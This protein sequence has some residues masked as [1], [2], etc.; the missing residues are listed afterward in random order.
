MIW[1]TK[2]QRQFLGLGLKT[3]LAMVCRLDHKTN[4]RMKTAQDTRRDLAACFPWK[5]DGLWFPSFASKLVM[6]RRRVLHVASSWRSRGS[7]AEDGPSDSVGGG[8]VEV[9]QK[10]PS[11]GVISFSAHRG[12]LVF[13]LDL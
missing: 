9:R 1:P 3:K 13:W 5:Q 6:E 4:G 12:I 11:L 2:S 7:E 10:Y 8:T